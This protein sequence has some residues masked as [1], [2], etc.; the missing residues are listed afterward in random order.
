MAV[1]AGVSQ[2]VE[3][4]SVQAINI[5]IEDVSSHF[6]FPLFLLYLL[7]YFPFLKLII[8]PP[9]AGEER[10]VTVWVRLTS[11]QI[12]VEA[13]PDLYLTDEIVSP[14]STIILQSQPQDLHHTTTALIKALMFIS[15][16]TLLKTSPV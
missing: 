12:D 1:E 5:D 9:S 14:I 6:L 7:Q 10:I 4:P 13:I 2:A 16:M 15:I 3:Y 11:P 8:M